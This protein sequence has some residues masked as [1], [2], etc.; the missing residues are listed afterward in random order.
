M[1]PT[2]APGTSEISAAQ[3]V[4]REL[5]LLWIRISSHTLCL[6]DDI[7]EVLMGKGDEYHG[8]LIAA[9]LLIM[10]RHRHLRRFRTT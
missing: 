9:N 1:E 4:R 8:I 6:K 2:P 5:F 7:L 3:R 10:C